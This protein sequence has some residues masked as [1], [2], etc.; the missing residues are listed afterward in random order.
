[1]IF[2]QPKEYVLLMVQMQIA[3]GRT[4]QKQNEYCPFFFFLQN[5]NVRFKPCK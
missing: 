4:K 2:I 3:G 1:M 5:L